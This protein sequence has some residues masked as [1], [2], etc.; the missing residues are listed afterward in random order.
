MA[1]S[2]DDKQASLCFKGSGLCLWQLPAEM[3]REK[4]LT[5][6]SPAVHGISNGNLGLGICNDGM[7][8]IRSHIPHMVNKQI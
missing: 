3:I 7:I 2:V 4:W 6:P 5:H 1:D 8:F